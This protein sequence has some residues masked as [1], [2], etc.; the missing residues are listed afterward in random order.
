MKKV[1]AAVIV[2]SLVVPAHA[3]NIAKQGVF[4]AGG[5]VL[6]TDGTFDPCARTV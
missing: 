4:S 3:V 1:L 5:L 2:L 6:T